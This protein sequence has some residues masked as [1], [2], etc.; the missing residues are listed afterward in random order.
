ME[1]KED[2]KPI[3]LFLTLLFTVM[4]VIQSLVD[5][6]RAESSLPYAFLNAIKENLVSLGISFLIGIPVA[7]VIAHKTK[8]R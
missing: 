3:M 6:Y 4:L 7:S 8:N 5:V 1:Q 2:K